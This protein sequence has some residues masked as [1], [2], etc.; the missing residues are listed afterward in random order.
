MTIKTHFGYVTCAQTKKYVSWKKTTNQNKLK[1]Y[2]KPLRN[3]RLA[4]LCTCDVRLAQK[5][6]FGNTFR[7]E[8][9]TL[10][11]CTYR[12]YSDRNTNYYYRGILVHIIRYN[13]PVF[14]V[15]RDSITYYT[16]AGSIYRCYLQ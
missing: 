13:V 5:F 14:Q 8:R 7:D 1:N 2:T 3:I 16:A 12:R 10:L 4:L 9:V 11:L 15:R 6:E